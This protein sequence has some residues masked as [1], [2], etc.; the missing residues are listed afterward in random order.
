MEC[1]ETQV[2]TSSMLINANFLYCS[3]RRAALRLHEAVL[4]QASLQKSLD[5]QKKIH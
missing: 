1:S 2:A 4:P 5:L 3:L